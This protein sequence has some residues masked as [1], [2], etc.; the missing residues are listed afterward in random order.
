MVVL[1]NLQYCMYIGMESTISTH[2]KPY[3]EEIQFQ[4]DLYLISYVF[5]LCRVNLCR[6]SMVTTLMNVSL[7]SMVMMVHAKYAAMFFY[8]PHYVALVNSKVD[9][10]Y[11]QEEEPYT[12]DTT[13]Y[14][15]SCPWKTKR[16]A[17]AGRLLLFVAV[18]L[19]IVAL[20]AC[21]CASLMPEEEEK[22]TT[23]GGV[24][25]LKPSFSVELL[26]PLTQ[27]QC[28]QVEF[29]GDKVYIATQLKSPVTFTP[30]Y[31]QPVPYYGEKKGIIF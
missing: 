24:S 6:L 29:S 12:S 23:K 22:N 26:V 18:G 20:F 4:V 31:P 7:S 10:V 30:G 14:H 27:K 25:L 9:Y 3:N 2:W 19:I 21:C 15:F 1:K 13:T 8:S 5:L 16:F 11:V 28:S 17:A